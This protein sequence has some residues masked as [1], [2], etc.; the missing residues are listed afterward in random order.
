MRLIKPESTSELSK[1]RRID[2]QTERV[3]ELLNIDPEKVM[4]NQHGISLTPDQADALLTLATIGYSNHWPS[5][6]DNPNIP[7][8]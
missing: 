8:M 2:Q 1:E 4:Y 6:D 5:D 7:G 3:A